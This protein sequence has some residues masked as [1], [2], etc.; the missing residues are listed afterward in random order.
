MHFN[1]TGICFKECVNVN[2]NADFHG[3]VFKC[4]VSSF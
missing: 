1:V 3:M 2:V 4:T